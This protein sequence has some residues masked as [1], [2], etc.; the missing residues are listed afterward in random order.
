MLN[1]E[2]L[3][4]LEYELGAIK[5]RLLEDACEHLWHII[6]WILDNSYRHA[7]ISEICY[8]LDYI[9]DV[10]DDEKLSEK[11]RGLIQQINEKIYGGLGL[12]EGVISYWICS[13]MNTFDMETLE[14]IMVELLK[15]VEKGGI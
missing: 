14:D 7:V 5:Q 4:V 1:K 8:W 12:L 3:E 13:E 6:D 10:E 2:V 15:D 9:K 11:T